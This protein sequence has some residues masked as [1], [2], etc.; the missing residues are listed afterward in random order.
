MPNTFMIPGWDIQANA[1]PSAHWQSDHG[2][3]QSRADR[4]G[5][6]SR[7]EV[8]GATYQIDPPRPDDDRHAGDPMRRPHG[9]PS[10]YDRPSMVDLLPAGPRALPLTQDIEAGPDESREEEF[11]RGIQQAA[12]LGTMHRITGLGPDTGL[13]PWV[14][15]DRRVS[16]RRHRPTFNGDD[17]AGI[18]YRPATAPADIPPERFLRGW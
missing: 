2:A 17:E 6:Y 7:R 15:R 1:E 5:Y 4:D 8:P 16:G 18:P 14:F 3:K 10:E 13:R 12:D 9:V 11:W